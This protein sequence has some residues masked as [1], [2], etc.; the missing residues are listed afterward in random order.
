M[1]NL[2]ECMRQEMF[3]SISYQITIYS[4]LIKKQ[5]TEAV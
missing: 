2:P 1:L 4:Q 3:L 5:I